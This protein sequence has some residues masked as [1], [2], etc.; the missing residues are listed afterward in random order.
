MHHNHL[1]GAGRTAHRDID[2][3]LP[4]P[5]EKRTLQKLLREQ[6]LEIVAEGNTDFDQDGNW[7]LVINSSGD[8]DLERRESGSW[9]NKATWT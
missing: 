7:R 8:L 4:S 3:Q 5:D 9:T 2:Q 6:K 1:Q